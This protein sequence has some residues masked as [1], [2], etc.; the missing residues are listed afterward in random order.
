[1]AE[2]SKAVDLSSII[3]RCVGSNPTPGISFAFAQFFLFLTL[4]R[5]LRMA[6]CNPHSFAKNGVLAQSEECNVS[7]VEVRGSK[8]RYSRSACDMP[9]FLVLR[10]CFCSVDF[11]PRDLAVLQYKP[12]VCL[13]T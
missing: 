2:R 8:P 7:N 10:D 13:G 11:H 9:F 1:M 12:H 4:T 3:V 6:F 5:A